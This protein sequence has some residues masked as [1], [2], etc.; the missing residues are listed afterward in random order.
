MR[1]LFSIVVNTIDNA[2][3]VP[4]STVLHEIGNM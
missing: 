2:V 1:N 4:S 3:P